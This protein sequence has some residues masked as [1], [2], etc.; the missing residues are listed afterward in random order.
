MER[1]LSPREKKAFHMHV[2]KKTYGQG[3]RD[4]SVPRKQNVVVRDEDEKGPIT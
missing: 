1:I 3:T 4:R 2:R